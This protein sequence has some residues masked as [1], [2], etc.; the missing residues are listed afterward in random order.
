MQLVAAGNSY[1]QALL[2]ERGD[3]ISQQ[4][5]L[6][7]KQHDLWRVRVVC[8]VC[9]KQT[10]PGRDPRVEEHRINILRTSCAS[11]YGQAGPLSRVP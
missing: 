11:D 2:C 5:L 10:W 8:T 1:L 9:G 3:T 7:E 4:D 6:H